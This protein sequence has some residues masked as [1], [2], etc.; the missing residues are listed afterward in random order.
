MSD[1]PRT[2]IVR[3][4]QTHGIRAFWRGC[5][6]EDCRNA[7]RTYNRERYAKALHA[8][9][10]EKQRH[11]AVQLRLFV[12]NQIRLLTKNGAS[13]NAIKK[14]TRA[15]MDVVVDVLAE[16]WDRGEVF[17]RKHGDDRLF[18]LKRAA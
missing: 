8:E 3:S 4:L 16:L 13:R 2:H 1:N 10:S 14:A 12:K 6:C 9:P 17:T 5:R 15:P 7:G 18:Y 11:D